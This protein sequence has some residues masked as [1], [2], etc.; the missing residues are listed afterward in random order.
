[1][2]LSNKLAVFNITKFRTKGQLLTLSGVSGSG[3]STLIKDLLQ[4]DMGFE[5][6][7]SATTRAR[8]DGEIDGIDQHFLTLDEFEYL[9]QNKELALACEVFGNYYAFLRDDLGKLEKGK[10]LITEYYH[11]ML[12]AFKEQFPDSLSA[13]IYPNNINTPL[14]ELDKR[15]TP[16]TELEKRKLAIFNELS[17]V[18][19]NAHMFDLIHTNNYDEESK[20]RFKGL[21]KEHLN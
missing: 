17:W 15:E 9:G 13:Y 6:L 5:K 2:Q 4:S 19:K 18:S 10:N 14:I 16:S 8:R 11:A 3:K 7:A 20:S 12:S 21:L 1:M